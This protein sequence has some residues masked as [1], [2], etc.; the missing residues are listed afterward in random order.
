M[1]MNVPYLNLSNTHTHTH[2]HTHTRA[3]THTYTHTHI[4]TTS[5]ISDVSN[6][7]LNITPEC[8]LFV[9]QLFGWNS[10]AESIPKR[11][12]TTGENKTEHPFSLTA[13]VGKQN[14][15]STNLDSS[16]T[17]QFQCNHFDIDK[18][19]MSLYW[20]KQHWRHS[21]GFSRYIHGYLGEEFVL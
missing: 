11:S 20:Y 5:F 14:C 3:H 10:T 2:T 18:D 13:H 19:M 17:F 9:L 15:S 8:G 7:P 16:Q 12:Q 6:F 1:Y 21:Y 4:R